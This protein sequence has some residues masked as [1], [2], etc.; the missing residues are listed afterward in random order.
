MDFSLTSSLGKEHAEELEKLLFFHPQQGRFRRNI[1]ANVERHGSPKIIESDRSLRIQLQLLAH[2]QSL[3]A[4]ALNGARQELVGA[5]VY[6]RPEAQT[7]EILHL[8]VRAE[9]TLFGSQA[10]RGLTF[11]LIEELC[12]IGRMIRGVH[13]VRL[14][15]SRGKLT[16]KAV[17]GRA[18]L[19]PED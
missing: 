5:L 11:L 13:F 6:T 3:Y 7:L 15:Y 12:R 14:P 19:A 17:R 8:V 16:L 18:Q 1:I 4:L 2:V 9:Y 10:N